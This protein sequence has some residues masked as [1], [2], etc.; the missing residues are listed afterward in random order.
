MNKKEDINLI[1]NVIKE[2]Q[3]SSS[4]DIDIRIGG[5]FGLCLQ[6]EIFEYNNMDIIVDDFSKI[7]WQLLNFGEILTESLNGDIKV[8][9]YLIEDTEINIR[10]RITYYSYLVTNKIMKDGLILENIEI[11]NEA[12]EW[13]EYYWE[14]ENLHPKC[15][16]SLNLIRVLK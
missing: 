13:L 16:E 12:K 7:N 2:I 1:K 8:R 5:S 9:S 6:G 14:T 3:E 10:E 11:I 15:I 4:S